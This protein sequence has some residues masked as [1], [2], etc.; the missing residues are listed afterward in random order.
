V[1]LGG[2]SGLD[3]CASGVERELSTDV[4]LVGFGFRGG[5]VYRS[6]PCTFSLRVLYTLS[7][8]HTHRAAVDVF[9]VIGVEGCR[10]GFTLD[11]DIHTTLLRYSTVQ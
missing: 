4:A 11:L 10:A 8:P 9:W 5:G 1:G 7:V 3:V 6:T 2:D